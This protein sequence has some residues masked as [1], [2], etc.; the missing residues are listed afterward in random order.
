[1]DINAKLRPFY[2]AKILYEKTDED[3]MLTT[4]QIEDILREEYGINTFRKTIK[5]DI[6]I[7]QKV[8]FDIEKIKSSQNKYHL[9]TRMFSVPELKLLMDA[10]ESSKFIS[11]KKSE[12]LTEK[13]GSLAGQHQAES[14]K[15]NIDV[16]GRIKPDNEQIYYIVDAINDAINQEK[17]ISFLY[18]TY[19]EL[20]EKQLKNNGKPYLFSPYKLVWNGDYYYMVGYSDKHQK[21]GMFRVDRIVKAP[22]I[23]EE[24]SVPIPKDFDINYYLNTMLRMYDGDR[25]KVKLICDND[26]I[27]S[28]IDKFGEDI[29]VRKNT[30]TTSLVAVEVAV[31]HIFFSWIF[32]FGGLV[33]IKSPS[34]VKEEF[35]KMI[36]LHIGN[37]N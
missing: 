19:N 3:H 1:M 20:K 29:E 22:D 28:I 31:N 11:K 15:R 12:N 30:K 37:T 35:D 32:G 27:D 23:L 16:E 18:F 2:I 13:L 26:V 25:K 7:L 21:I 14:L 9:L 34:S 4:A 10:V 33:R 24:D 36:R 5:A 6:E 8:G 17:K